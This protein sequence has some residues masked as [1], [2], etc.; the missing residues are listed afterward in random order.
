LGLGIIGQAWARNL[1]SDGVEVRTWN[2]TA[3]DFATQFAAFHT[4]VARAVEGAQLII[5]V[6]ADPPAVEDVLRQIE[7]VLGPHQI[8]VQAST[9]SPE[10][11]AKFA[12]QVQASGA[13][14]LE[15]PFT[16]SKPAAQARQTVFYAGGDA[17]VLADARPTLERLSKAILHIGPLGSASALKLAM[18][19]NIAA[20]A[21]ALSEGLTLCR[22]SGISDDTFFDALHLNVARSGL[23]DLKEPKLRERDYA[24]QFSVK[25]MG[26]DLRLA[27]ESAALLNLELP[28]TQA[29]RG[30][31]ERGIESNMGDDDF[32]GLIRLL[33][34]DA[35]QK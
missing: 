3:R 32:I 30:V 17:Q 4:D 5:L 10:R 14:Y 27:L 13:K 25:H 34:P 16:G 33:S 35:S 24:P 23:S 8:L 22:Q 7:P 18:N 9:I 12:A 28:Q 11:T 6:V 15:A 21:G 20:V 29:V 1:E 19:L 31:Y 26:K 2:R